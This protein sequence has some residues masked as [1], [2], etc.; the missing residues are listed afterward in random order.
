MNCSHLV[1]RRL[2]T[3]LAALLFAAACAIPPELHRSGLGTSIGYRRMRGSAY[4]GLNDTFLLRFDG[5][6]RPEGWPLWLS[7]GLGLGHI[8]HEV[9][10]STCFLL[11]CTEPTTLTTTSVEFDLGVRRWAAFAGHPVHFFVGAG[12]ALV[13]GDTDHYLGNHAKTGDTA[14]A[15]GVYVEGGLE[16]PTTSGAVGLQARAFRGESTTMFGAPSDNDLDEIMLFWA[17][18]W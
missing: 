13:Y 4:S 17:L 3:V 15:L 8:S 16:L 6:T 9:N 18:R 11:W 14:N 10:D 7:T 2:L 12:G 5:D 1:D